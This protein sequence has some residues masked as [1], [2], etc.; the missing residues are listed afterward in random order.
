ME[1]EG[2]RKGKEKG[3]DEVRARK[4]GGGGSLRTKPERAAQ[5][6]MS[7]N[8]EDG[9]ERCAQH[10][11]WVPAG[12]ACLERALMLPFRSN[13]RLFWCVDEGKERTRAILTT[14]WATGQGQL[15]ER[16][17]HQEWPG[18]GATADGGQ[19]RHRKQT[20]WLIS[21]RRC[22]STLSVCCMCRHQ[23]KHT[24]LV[25]ATL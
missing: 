24:T 4:E 21:A 20:N 5:V 8:L 9:Q 7:G 18:K 19:T 22:R 3:R 23:R 10:K 25:K 1:G 16:G 17:A 2:G 11:K 14:N 12:R 6:L 15:Q 13:A